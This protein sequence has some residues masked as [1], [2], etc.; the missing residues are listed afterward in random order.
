MSI[1]HK[2]QKA[3]ENPLTERAGALWSVEED[4]QLCENLL[5]S[6]TISEICLEHKRT[7]G[8]I[9]FRSRTLAYNE[10]IILT[11]NGSPILEEQISNISKLY[12]I[13]P[14]NLL[15]FIDDKEAFKKLKEEEKKIKK[16]EEEVEEASEIEYNYIYCLREREFIKSGEK[17]YKIGKTSKQPF[18]RLKQYPKE[19][20]LILLLKVE[21]CHS[22]ESELISLFDSKYEQAKNIGREYY[23]GNVNDMIQSILELTM[24]KN[25]LIK[26]D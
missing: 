5:S 10:Y 8:S 7:L 22:T 11:S 17:I 15:A 1:Y 24:N 23:K 18:K 4:S 20:E 25:K 14:I 13:K 21:D 6:K 12:R 19:S 2:I 9:G 26:S 16:I 3:K